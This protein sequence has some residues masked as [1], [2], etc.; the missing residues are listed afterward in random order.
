MT[1]SPKSCSDI[2]YL[3][4]LVRPVDEN[5]Y[6]YSVT[7][8]VSIDFNLKKFLKNILYSFNI[9]KPRI[10]P[11]YS[12]QLIGLGIIG[13]IDRVTINGVFLKEQEDYYR[14][15]NSNIITFDIDIKD[16][17]VIDISIVYSKRDFIIHN[18]LY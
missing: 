5:T 4:D 17:D 16:R 12:L 6:I 15:Y 13:T 11:K 9:F 8:V 2:I 10:R 7:K 1:S 18:L 3:T 14:D